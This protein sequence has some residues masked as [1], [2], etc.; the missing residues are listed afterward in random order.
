MI[1]HFVGSYL[2]PL[3]NNQSKGEH[4]SKV[5]RVIEEGRHEITKVLL[6]GTDDECR[7]FIK[8]IALALSD[9]K[10]LDVRTAD[11]F[12][13]ASW[14]VGVNE[15]HFWVKGRWYIDYDA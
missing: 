9:I 4:M 10:T 1:K 8:Q 11:H 2:T 7:T 6:E 12:V 3:R 14:A 13:K 5:V 15:T